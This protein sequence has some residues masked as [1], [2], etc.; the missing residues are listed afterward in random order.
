MPGTWNI[1]QTTQTAPPRESQ[2]GATVTVVGVRKDAGRG[3]G[4]GEGTL[5]PERAAGKALERK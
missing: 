3:A 1:Q 5:D 2:L 4:T